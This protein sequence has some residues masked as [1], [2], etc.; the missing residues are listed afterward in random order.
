MWASGLRNTFSL[1]LHTN[2]NV[3][4]TD[5]GPNKNFGMFSTNCNG[6][7]KA[8]KNIPD[9]LFK[10]QPG[11]WHG[12]PNINRKQCVF[13]GT[14]VEPLK[15]NLQSSTNGILEYRSNTFGGK[16]KGD[17]FIVKFAVNGEGKMSRAQLDAAG[18][19]KPNGFTNLFLGKSGLAIVEGP[20]GEMVMPRVYQ[21]SIL[22]AKPSY[23]VP[24]VTTLISVLPNRGSAGGGTTIQIS[25]HHFGA[26][27]KV[28]IGGQQCLNIKALDKDTLTCV[29]PKGKPNSKVAI[30]VTGTKG[31]ATSIGSDYWYF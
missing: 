12:H 11:K 10:V 29:T 28:T 14:Q 30:S 24:V 13:G 2:G 9:K 23:P 26:T 5:N 16:I 1:H 7:Q 20:R 25:G 8:S 31:I 4:A 21:S 6:G 22:V 19:I 17:L 27:P 3:Y 15:S 18:N